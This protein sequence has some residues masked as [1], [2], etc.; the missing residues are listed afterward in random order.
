MKEFAIVEVGSTNTKGY[1]YKEEKIIELPFDFIEFKKNYSINGYILDE[2]KQKLFKYIK[3]MKEITNKI[4]VYGTSIFRNI[5]NVE[6]EDFLEEFENK[7]GIKFIIVSSDEEE[8][9]TVAGVVANI[10]YNGNIAVMIGGGGSTEI[11][12][13]NNKKV[14]EDV[15]LNIGGIDILSQHPDLADDITKTD[16]D[17]VVDY[18]KKQIVNIK[19]NADILVLAGSAN[20]YFRTTANYKF[21][22]KVPFEYNEEEMVIIDA[23]SLNEQDR[24]YFYVTSLNEMKK[25]MLDMPN[26]WNATRAIICFVEAVSDLVNAK[27]VVASNITMVYGIVEEIKNNN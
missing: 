5:N 19:N 27:Y 6:K 11:A 25:N 17:L 26:W 22:E 20:K 3:K 21:I 1:L 18:I 14:I 7:T 23:K 15:N 8:K 4:Y 16:I 12:I 9:Y 2:D 10:T 24:N 13:V